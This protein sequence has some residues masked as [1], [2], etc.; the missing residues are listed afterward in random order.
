[1]LSKITALATGSLVFI[2]S[3]Q[4]ELISGW[5]SKGFV[6]GTIT[7]G[8]AGSFLADPAGNLAPSATFESI[9]FSQINTTVELSGSVTIQNAAGNIQFRFGLFDTNGSANDQGWLGYYASPRAFSGSG[10]SVV[11]GRSGTG[12]GNYVSGTGAYLT[13]LTKT[14]A[15]TASAGS[16]FD[17]TLTLTRKDVSL[18]EGSFLFVQT[19]GTGTINHSG[20]FSDTGASAQAA[21]NSI[22]AVG[23]L[24]NNDTGDINFSNVSVSVIP[25]P[26]SFASIAGLACIGW[27]AT[28]RRRQAA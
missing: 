7:E 5:T 20:T 26:S 21:F 3:A 12:T 16:S 6:S 24:V 17:F 2:S 23:F 1:M 9:D 22:N 15:G 14:D 11:N 4:A 19:G 13:T 27:V 18:V 25:E 8:V 28:R 10:N